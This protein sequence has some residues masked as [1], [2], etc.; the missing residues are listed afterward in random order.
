MNYYS[1]IRKV[2]AKTFL[3]YNSVFHTTKAKEI[4]DRVKGRSE[5]EIQNVVER[6]LKTLKE[7]CTKKRTEGMLYFVKVNE[8]IKAKNALK[9]ET[10][11][12]S[13]ASI[14]NQ[15]IASTVTL[16]NAT[17][18]EQSST[19]PTTIAAASLNGENAIIV[20]KCKYVARAQHETELALTHM[21]TTKLL[22]LLL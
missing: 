18:T 8:K 1:E 20:T 7:Y 17:S 22:I 19:R 9:I 13:S 12:T 3:Q 14:I 2:V 21:L 6:G 5:N 10:A 15:N 4:Y 11:A 16:N